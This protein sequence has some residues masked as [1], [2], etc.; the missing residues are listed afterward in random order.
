MALCAFAGLRLGEAAGV[1]AGDI[2]TANNVL[3]VRRQVRGQV[4]DQHEIVAPK[5]GSERDVPIPVSLTDLLTAHI[6]TVGT[7]GDEGWLFQSGDALLNRN[8]A[9]DQWRLIRQKVGPE[10]FTLHGL[11]HFYAS[12]LIITGCD[13]VTV[14]RAL[15]HASASITLNIYSHLWPTAE[16]RTRSAAAELMAAVLDPADCVRTDET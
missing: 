16:D 4:R 14:Q 5:A 1:R 13:V 9:G 8:S 6:K 11:R 2:D 3:A 10:A 12:A 7:L 15:G